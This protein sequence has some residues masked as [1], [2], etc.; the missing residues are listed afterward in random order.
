MPSGKRKLPSVLGSISV[1]DTARLLYLP[2]LV[3]ANQVLLLRA[4]RTDPLYAELNR[5]CCDQLDTLLSPSTAAA[6][7]LVVVR[8]G[9]GNLPVF[10]V[11]VDEND[12]SALSR[13]LDKLGAPRF[14][15]S[16]RNFGDRKPFL[17]SALKQLRSARREVEIWNG[18]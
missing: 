18:I 17:E 11:G 16:E 7:E 14:A 9:F 10:S 5:A 8:T 15:Y 4:D 3:E 6:N 1:N 2:S 13:A 12:P